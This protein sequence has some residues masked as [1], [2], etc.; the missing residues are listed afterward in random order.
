MA[1]VWCWHLVKTLCQ[2]HNVLKCFFRLTVQLC[3]PD[4]VKGH[5]DTK[6]S[7]GA[8]PLTT[9]QQQYQYNTKQPQGSHTTIAAKRH[10]MTEHDAETT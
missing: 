2:A 7:P 6:P 1:K 9:D 10:P 3:H 4:D 8:A 5:A